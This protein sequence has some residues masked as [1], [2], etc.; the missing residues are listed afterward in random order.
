MRLCRSGSQRHS[1]GVNAGDLHSSSRKR[2][3][4]PA[5]TQSEK[6][7]GK[8]AKCQSSQ[9]CCKQQKW[10]AELG[11][12]RVQLSVSMRHPRVLEMKPLTGTGSHLGTSVILSPVQHL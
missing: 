1:N 4:T 5:P 11:H 9:D 7:A 10:V 12:W 8:A 2:Y 6:L 3:S